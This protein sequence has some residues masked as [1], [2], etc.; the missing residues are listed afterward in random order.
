MKTWKQNQIINIVTAWQNKP[1]TKTPTSFT[2]N[3]TSML[4]TI[5]QGPL[6]NPPKSFL[7]IKSTAEPFQKNPGS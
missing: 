1:A 4:G 3:Y 7:I 5:E 6:K 2:G